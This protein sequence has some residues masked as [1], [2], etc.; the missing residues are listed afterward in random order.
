MTTG[1]NNAWSDYNPARSNYGERDPMQ[2]AAARDLTL[3]YY[4]HPAKVRDP[5][6]PYRRLYDL[7]SL[8]C[9]LLE[10]GLWTTLDQYPGWDQLDARGGRVTARKIASGRTL[11]E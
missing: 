8:G 1:F 6:V 7:Y 11:D 2:R 3:D 4:Q 5:S 10:L 9:V